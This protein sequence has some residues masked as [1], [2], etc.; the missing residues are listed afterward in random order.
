KALECFNEALDICRKCLTEYNTDVAD[1]HEK[2]AH[3]HYKHYNK[4]DILVEISR[5]AIY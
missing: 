1:C 5:V 3:I 2:I 4:I